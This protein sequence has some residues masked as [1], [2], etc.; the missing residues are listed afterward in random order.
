MT[1]GKS[2]SN[3]RLVV[4]NRNIIIWPIILWVRQGY[5]Q[6]T[7]SVQLLCLFWIFPGRGGLALDYG[8]WLVTSQSILAIRFLPFPDSFAARVA[9]W[10]VLANG[11]IVFISR[12]FSYTWVHFILLKSWIDLEGGVQLGR[13]S[14]YAGGSV[15]WLWVS[16]LPWGILVSSRKVRGVGWCLRGYLFIRCSSDFLPGPSPFQ[17]FSKEK[18]LGGSLLIWDIPGAMRP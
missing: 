8:S 15:V 12:R 11:S 14:I 1:L 6:I 9:M 5:L 17:L 2:L 7:H 4:C 13:D 10:S 18:V 16:R 3:I